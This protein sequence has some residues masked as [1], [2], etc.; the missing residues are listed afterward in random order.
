[1]P[2]TSRPD[3]RPST[4]P[5]VALVENPYEA[6]AEW[7]HID[8]LDYWD[9]NPRDNDKTADLVAE[10]MIAYGF[11]TPMMAW[12]DPETKRD[13]IIA[14][15]T[16]KKSVLIVRR[17][18]KEATPD[19]LLKWHAGALR[20][21]QTGMVPVRLRSDLTAEQAT[22]LA[23][24]DNKSNELSKWRPDLLAALMRQ[25]PTGKASL[26]GW[27]DGELKKLLR[28][29]HTVTDVD[30]QLERA[31]ELK[32]LWKTKAGQLWRCGVHLVYCGDCRNSNEVSIVLGGKKMVLVFTDPP[33]GVDIGKKNKLLNSI[34]PSNRNL[35][36]IESDSLDPEE[37]K[38]QLVPAFINVRDL[39]MGEDCTFFMTAPSNGSMGL[40]MQMM[41]Q[42][43]G[44]EIR[45]VL[46]WKKN[47]PT[48]SM[49]KLD[50][51]YKHEPIFMT[52]GKRHKRL[53]MGEFRTSVWDIDRPRA[54]PDHATGKPVA[55]YIN[56]IL[57][58]TDEGD[59]AFD[60]YAGGG[61]ML[62]ACEQTKRV[63]YLMEKK[64]EFVAVILQRW[65]DAT[66]TKPELVQ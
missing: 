17:R 36:D 51:D 53:M 6:A 27:S 25:M 11:G 65:V 43:V 7:R 44:L 54:S 1:M 35:S 14:G 13:R 20:M 23:L 60:G 3:K 33:Y 31:N 64:P 59:G 30:P 46:I 55:L 16:R 10:L 41:M 37:L 9:K 34:Q 8:T 47:Q 26:L 57:N 56:A 42:E 45:H 2:R 12:P 24:A 49:G 15:N 40:M 29:S 22:E 5:P 58:H 39:V 50:Y 32:K 18:F 63:A 61:P 21:A 66:G 48:F 4:R 19:V 52:W 28:V 38:A 62:I